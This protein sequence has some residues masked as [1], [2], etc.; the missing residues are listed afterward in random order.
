ML[1]VTRVAEAF[2]DPRVTCTYSAPPW[3]WPCP[4]TFA[5]WDVSRPTPGHGWR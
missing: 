4:S 2:S 1:A 5:I 3:T